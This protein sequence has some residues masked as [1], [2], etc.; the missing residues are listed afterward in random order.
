MVVVGGGNG[1]GM[2]LT[3]PAWL[4]IYQRSSKHVVQLLKERESVCVRKKEAGEVEREEKEDKRTYRLDRGE[5]QFSR[6]E[7]SVPHPEQQPLVCLRDCPT[8]DY[9]HS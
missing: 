4:K 7:E 3:S 9:E 8:C 2:R 6:H 5:D 1:A